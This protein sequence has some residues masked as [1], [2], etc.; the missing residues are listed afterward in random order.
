MPKLKNL[1]VFGCSLTKDNMIDTWA[2][3][4]AAKLQCNLSNFA[5]RGAGYNYI[6]QKIISTP[7]DQDDLVVVMW[8]SADRFDL[9]VNDATPH[10]QQDVVRSSWLDGTKPSFVDY[11]G[12]YNQERGWYING[13]V[14]RGYKHYYYKYFYTQTMHVNAAWTSIVLIQN[15][16]DKKQI[17]YLMCNSYP[18]LDLIQYHDDTIKD[19]NTDIYQQ[20]NLQKFVQDADTSGFINLVAAEKFVF[21]NPHYPNTDA[22]QWYLDRYIILKL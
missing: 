14:P 10:L 15:Y 11:S 8:P 6:V 20:I 5:E 16:L 9:Y 7:I 21:F 3:L 1:C 19:F 22:H 18:L 13:S 12:R 2:N 4:L 17:P